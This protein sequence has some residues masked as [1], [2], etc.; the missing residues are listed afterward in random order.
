MNY[1]NYFSEIEQTFIRRR[2]R[3]LLLSPLDWALIETWQE[4]GIPL[5]IVLRG[6]ERVFDSYE[7]SANRRR[8][9]KSLTY[10]KEE[11]EAQYAEWLESRVGKNGRSEKAG[12]DLPAAAAETAEAEDEIA[13]HLSEPEIT[14][15]LE[16]SVAELTAAGERAAGDLKKL[17]ERSAGRLTELIADRP[18]SRAKLG[19]ILEEMDEAID[20]VLVGSY[21]DERIRTGVKKQIA[22]YRERMDENAY[23][24]TYE[25]MLIKA[26]RE[27]TRIPRLGLFYL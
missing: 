21:A 4:R 23:R 17:L 16:R 8:T 18:P 20:R 14:E 6:I 10:C 13:G 5:R 2:G 22:A 9:I 3:N 15:H 27:Q 7:K 1:F 19:R 11:I 25:L 26:L 24:R 12:E